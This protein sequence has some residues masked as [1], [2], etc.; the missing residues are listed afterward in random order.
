MALVHTE[1]GW[2]A[3]LS[4]SISKSTNAWPKRSARARSLHTASLNSW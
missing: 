4:T 1:G 2:C 3:A